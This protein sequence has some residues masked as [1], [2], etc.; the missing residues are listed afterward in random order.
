[1]NGGD[2]E[3]WECTNLQWEGISIQLRPSFARAKD[4]GTKAFAVSLACSRAQ[5]RV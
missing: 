1:M 5:D 4:S 3:R 2:L